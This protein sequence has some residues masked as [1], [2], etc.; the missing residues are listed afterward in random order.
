MRTEDLAEGRP[1][2]GGRGDTLG[3]GAGA[4]LPNHE[5]FFGTTSSFENISGSS[6]R[7]LRSALLPVLEVGR[8]ESVVIVYLLAGWLWIDSVAKRT[9]GLRPTGLSGTAVFSTSVGLTDVAGASIASPAWAA[10]SR[11]RASQNTN[12]SEAA[13]LSSSDGRPSPATLTPLSSSELSESELQD[14]SSVE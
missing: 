13:C 4:L 11:F 7:L 9:A 1:G 5:D 8:T 14:E 12:K 3:A 2:F 10:S 6:L